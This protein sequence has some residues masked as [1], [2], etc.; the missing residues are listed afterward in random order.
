MCKCVNVWSR[1]TLDPGQDPPGIPDM[2]FHRV[3]TTSMISLTIPPESRD[4]LT[5]LRNLRNN[6]FK[7]S[8]RRSEW[9]VDVCV[10]YRLAF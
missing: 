3:E 6:P 9:D 8:K 2:L 10:M 1:M 7:K 5:H 4:S